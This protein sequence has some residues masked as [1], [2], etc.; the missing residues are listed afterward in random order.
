MTRRIALLFLLL[1][2]FVAPAAL[3]QAQ[4]DSFQRGECTADG[5][6][7]YS[8]Q[9][10]N[11]RQPQTWENACATTPANVQGQFFATPSRCNKTFVGVGGE[12]GEFDVNDTTC[13]IHLLPNQ[14]PN[15][16]PNPN[17]PI[18]G[19]ADTHNHQF[20]HLGF[21]G[22]FI[23]GKTFDPGGIAAAL[24]W[25][26]CI[27]THTVLGCPPHAPNE[28]H[29]SGGLAD[30]LGSAMT[31]ASGVGKVDALAGANAAAHI[32][33]PGLAP[34]MGLPGHFVGGYPQFD[35]W[36]RWN[37]LDHQLAYY[38]W[39]K[40]AHAGGMQ[41][42]VMM[43]VN[44]ELL[45]APM[46]I[47]GHAPLGCDD[48]QA[49][50]GQLAAAKELEAYVDKY[51]GGWYRIVRSPA[52]ARQA[53]H[54]GQLAVVLG[55][56]VANLFGCARLPNPCTN[57]QKGQQYVR[58]QLQKYY[59]TGVRHLFAIAHTDNAFGGT[60][61]FED[62]YQLNN[63]FFNRDGFTVYD[64]SPE[65]VNFTLSISVIEQPLFQILHSLAPRQ[66]P[67]YPAKGQCN[68]QDLTGLGKFLIRDMMNLHMIIDID[69]MSWRAADE[70]LTMAE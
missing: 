16:N 17:A 10:L 11:V 3:G 2:A 24:P 22:R 35:G 52:E 18:W 45:C 12:W 63:M 68:A 32:V 47:T 58:T 56:E 66:I 53:I 61:I 28:I 48:M 40:R 49:V 46:A 39:L 14:L 59:A 57:D 44:L 1:F 25:C 20:A 67:S 26:D 70:A 7:K 55:I 34:G 6:R 33:L 30:N 38:Q 41:L 5:K 64:C 4:W 69:H 50:D 27:G 37:T 43:A 19:F 21:G 9:I 54:K 15:A 51:D 36:P 13:E 29:G 23:W 65:N 42:M 62:I 31:L 8:A 60:A